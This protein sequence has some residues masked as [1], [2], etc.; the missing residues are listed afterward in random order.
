MQVNNARILGVE[1]DGEVSVV[2]EY[3]LEDFKSIAAGQVCFHFSYINIF[4][5]F[6]NIVIAVIFTKI[7][8]L[9]TL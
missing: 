9:I 2:E 5:L 7:T 6:F 8:I 1:V 3:I 4:D